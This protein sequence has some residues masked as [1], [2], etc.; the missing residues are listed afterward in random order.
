MG[1][2]R[3]GMSAR[4]RESRSRLAQL[5]SSSALLRATLTVRSRVCG[6]PGCR[7]VSGERHTSLYI[8]SRRE[9]R[10]RQVCVPRSL[11]EAVREWAAT[12]ERARGLL[13]EI[14]EACW[15]LVQRRGR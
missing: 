3:G 8:V 1:V 14:S 9:G 4:E 13:D 12:Y 15:A 6:K 10:V 11:E 7:C 5:V 2:P